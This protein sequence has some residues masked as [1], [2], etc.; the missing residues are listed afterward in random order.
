M[1]ILTYQA[2]ALRP[3]AGKGRMKKDSEGYVDVVLG[4]VNDYNSRGEY[5]LYEGTE[6]LFTGSSIFARRIKNG[7]L[8]SELTHPKRESGQ[9][10][11]DYFNRLLSIDDKQ[12]STHIKS[13]TL[14]SELWKRNRTSM[15]EGSIGVIGKIKPYGPYSN[16]TLEAINT[17]SINLAY[18]VRSFT[19]NQLI[20]NVNVKKMVELVTW[21]QVGAQGI[22]CANKWDS[23]GLEV[24]FD[25]V[26]SMGDIIDTADALESVG[27]ESM[28]A[29]V[30]K[31]LHHVDESV[32]SNEL[33]STPIWAKWK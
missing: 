20:N 28:A 14:D 29:R 30:R 26:L 9:S 6:K 3:S 33:D 25:D 22:A 31:L 17:P 24:L 16:V 11:R 1:S 23:P 2:L 10:R 21:D 27:N 8:F 4:A 12:V 13:V 32:E 5:Y 18:S 7:Q 15:S 19:K